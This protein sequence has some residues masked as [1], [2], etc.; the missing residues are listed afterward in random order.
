MVAKSS[1]VLSELNV[2]TGASKCESSGDG[3]ALLAR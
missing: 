2:S 1:G 3:S